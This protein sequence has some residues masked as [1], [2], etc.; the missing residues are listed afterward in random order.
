[1]QGL[2]HKFQYSAP[3]VRKFRLPPRVAK[4][5][6]QKAVTDE[7][8]NVF[9]PLDRENIT[10]LKRG[11]GARIEGLNA[12]GEKQI[13]LDFLSGISVNNF[14]NANT[15]VGAAVIATL[16]GADVIRKLTRV[17]GI[18]HV[19][20]KDWYVAFQKAADLPVSS[21]TSQPGCAYDNPLLERAHTALAKEFG[22][23]NAKVWLANSGTEVT[24]AAINAMRRYHYNQGNPDKKIIVSFTGCY[25]GKTL[26]AVATMPGDTVGRGEIPSDF[27]QIPLNDIKSLKK[28]FQENSGKIAGAIIE[29]VQGAGG[30]IPANLDFL[31][32]LRQVT[33]AE[34]ALLCCDCV[35]S[36]VGRTGVG[37]FGYEDAENFKPD[38]AVIAKALGGG[39]LPV[40]AMILSE[41]V[42]EEVTKEYAMD[43]TMSASPQALAAIVTTTDLLHEDP[44]FSYQQIEK[45]SDYMEG[46]LH[47]IAKMFPEIVKK[48][49]GKG[50]MRAV[51]LQDDFKNFDVA[52][53]LNENGLL[54]FEAR[55]NSIRFLPPLNVTRKEIDEATK[56]M[57]KVFNKISS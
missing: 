45:K 5:V 55:N 3:S 12:R 15:R 35:Q 24:E 32:A 46:K 54:C 31:Q 57:K 21:L 9:F 4:P 8:S 27:R 42:A 19:I 33:K 29:P 18:K 56:I 43:C 48:M 11:E 37:Y 41:K 16:T 38:I 30:M 52:Q 10:L 49:T 7:A 17:P 13:Y 40:S 44:F 39:V 22:E 36:G 6:V 51:H 14:G 28:F 53:K 2:Q 20:G 47:E 34:N 23:R 50:L 26:G 25:H 1:M